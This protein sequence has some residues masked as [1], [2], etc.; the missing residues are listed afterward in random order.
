MRTREFGAQPFTG[1]Q[2]VRLDHHPAV[3]PASPGKPGQWTFIVVDDDFCTASLRCD[4]PLSQHEMLC[5]KAVDLRLLRLWRRL[6]DL[7]FHA[8]MRTSNSE[9]L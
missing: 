3:T 6:F 2:L 4:L 5:A 7:M 9:P 1:L 8:H